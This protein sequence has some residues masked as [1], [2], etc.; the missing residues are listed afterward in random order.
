MKSLTNAHITTEH[1]TRVEN[2][3]DLVYKWETTDASP[4]LA[5]ISTVET[6]GVFQQSANIPNVDRAGT[7]PSSANIP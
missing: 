1:I 2:N 5:D 3:L 7:T 6:A 4:P